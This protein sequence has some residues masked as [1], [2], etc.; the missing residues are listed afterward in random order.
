MTG[1][2]LLGNGDELAYPGPSSGEIG[3]SHVVRR[4]VTKGGNT[5]VNSN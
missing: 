3:T 2:D 5:H 4:V 1:F